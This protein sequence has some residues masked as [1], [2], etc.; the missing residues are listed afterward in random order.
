M[1][2]CGER[3]EELVSICGTCCG[4]CPAYRR[5]KCPGCH[6]VNDK[7]KLSCAMYRCAAEKQIQTCFLCEEFP[8]NIH[9]EKGLIYKHSF[10][11]ALKNRISQLQGEPS[12]NRTDSLAYNH[13]LARTVENGKKLLDFGVKF[14]PTTT[15]TTN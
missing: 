6:E 2:L 4:F 11:E 7:A 14:Y 3:L 12:A 5:Q 10:L 13:L 8:C 9:F 1:S 15:T